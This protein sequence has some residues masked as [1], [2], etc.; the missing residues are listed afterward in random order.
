VICIVILAAGSSSRMGRPK[1]LLPLE[2]KSLIRRVAEEAIASTVRQTVVVT[3]AYRPEVERELAGLALKLVHNPDHAEGMSTS[4]RAGL[5]ALRP[6]C[7]AALIMLGDQPLVDREVL[8]ALFEVRRRSGASIVQ[9]R[10]AGEP[11]NPILWDRRHFAELMRQEGDQ[12]GRQVLRERRDE[13]VWCELPDARVRADVDTP[14]AYETLRASLEGA[15]G[16][17]PSHDHEHHGPRFCTRCGG[18]LA[19]RDVEGRER[20]AC[21]ACHAVHWND[22][23]VAV[24]VLIPWN[25][26][27][28]LGKRAID[29]G[30]GR[31]S[32]PSGYV[33]RG[34]IVEEA[35]RRE[36]VEETGLDVAITGLVGVY[37]APGNPVI[38]VAYAAEV[39]AGSASPGPEVAELAGFPADA[40]PDM[41][42]AHDDRIVRDWLALRERHAPDLQ[43]SS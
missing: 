38:L 28:L 18:R 43:G 39:T 3:G 23:K 22:P 33:D 15:V 30:L 12:G 41:A 1:L 26:G 9:P 7:D 20:P 35:A 21:E 27:V 16:A 17:P 32:F 42:F 29:P 31:W 6:E 19:P 5:R 37:S 10:Y 40:L 11:G 25:G 4:L 8:N 36:V 24:A 13:I 34:E 14:E 2:G